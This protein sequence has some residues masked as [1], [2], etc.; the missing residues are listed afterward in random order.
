MLRKIVAIIIIVIVTG[1][2]TYIIHDIYKECGNEC[3]QLLLMGI[4][5]WVVSVGFGLAVYN[6]VFGE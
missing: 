3:W 1:C 5:F 6:K 2:Y 4:L